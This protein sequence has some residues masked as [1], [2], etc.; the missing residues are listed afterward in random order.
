MNAFY[1]TGLSTAQ[2]YELNSKYAGNHLIVGDSAEP[3]LIKELFD[4]KLN[5]VECTKGQGSVTAG[6]SLM[7][8]YDIIIDASS[9]NLIKEFNNYSWIDKTNKSVPIDL[10][11]HGIDACRYFISKVLANP[12]RN[13]YYIK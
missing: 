8:E 3:R 7:L 12:H 9:V 2:L 13:K 10:W 5:I 4:R 1:E 11:N 6:I